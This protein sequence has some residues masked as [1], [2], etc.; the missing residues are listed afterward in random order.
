MLTVRSL[1]FLTI[2]AVAVTAQTDTVP[3][4][5]NHTLCEL[6]NWDLGDTPDPNAPPGPYPVKGEQVYIQDAVKANYYDK[7]VPPTIVQAEGYVQSFCMGNYLAPGA[8]PLPAGGVTAAHV[9]KNTGGPA[10]KRYWQITGRLNCQVLNITCTSSSPGAFDD[11]GQYD[12]V[13]YRK[14]GKEPYSG[15]DAS[16]HPGLAHYVE[17]AGN[18]IFCMRV[19]DGGQDVGDPCNPKNDTAGCVATM[20]FVDQ[21][22]FSFTD[23]GTGQTATF[24]VS[25]PASSAT[26]TQSG[27]ATSTSTSKVTSSPSPATATGASNNGVGVFGANVERAILLAVVTVLATSFLATIMLA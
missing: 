20:G 12:D 15:V 5:L 19:C 24:S 26:P 18:G 11:G 17:Q 27:G 3:P 23:M 4:N 22:G 25:L 9:I 1:A 8:L 14:C 10:G 6:R 7:G 2:S 16:K 21:D 13:A